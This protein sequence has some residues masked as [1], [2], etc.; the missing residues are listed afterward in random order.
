[1]LKKFK[2]TKQANPTPEPQ[3]LFMPERIT[4]RE[5]CLIINNI[6]LRTLVV[7][8]FSAKI[9]QPANCSVF[10]LFFNKTALP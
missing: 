8:M 3:D 9:M 6:F 4:E 7:D 2:Q 10:Y 5:D 1:L